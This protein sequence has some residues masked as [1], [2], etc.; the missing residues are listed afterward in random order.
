MSYVQNNLLP[1]EQIKFYCQPHW[2]V[3]A[4]PILTIIIAGFIWSWLPPDMIDFSFGFPVPH[5]IGI[6][7]GLYALYTLGGAFIFFRF[8]EYAV[9]DRRVIMKTGLIQR[10]ALEIFLKRVEAINVDQSILGRMLGYGS[11]YIIGTGGSRDR[12]IAVPNPLEFR[13]VVQEETD[14]IQQKETDPN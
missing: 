10:N 5:V 2:I 14:L 1:S 4:T 6:I 3:F 11:V 8:S 13:R 7:I 9:T 12:Y